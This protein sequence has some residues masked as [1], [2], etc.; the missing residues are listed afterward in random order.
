MA[1]IVGDSAAAFGR[2]AAVLTKLL[3][4][5]GFLAYVLTVCAVFLLSAYLGFS[6]FVR[7]GAT[8]VPDVVG[9]PGSEAAN[10][11]A[12]QGLKARI[13]KEKE[14]YDDKIPFGR[15]VRQ[16]PE[17]RT[18][19][20][21]G[22]SVELILSLGP[23]RVTTPQMAGNAMT[24]A[25]VALT[26]TGLALGRILKAYDATASPDTV[27]AQDPAAGASIAPA[28][29]VDLLLA[30]SAPTER[31]VMPDLVYRNY[32][33]VRPYFDRRNFRFGNVRFERYEGVAAGVILRQFPL[34][35]H[36]LT[37]N[38]PI[39]LVVATSENLWP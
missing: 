36:P 24:T 25:Q 31:Y 14:R 29:S 32:D 35:G 27:I 11:L 34:P 37:K 30:M 3:R 20:K 4:A 1:A 8:P 21:R 33:L 7:S 13:P 23:R 26:K 17:A 5:L 10:Q 38:D 6:F 39:S 12:D 22:G 9:V 16:R 18:F 15:V 2:L 28:S 19:A